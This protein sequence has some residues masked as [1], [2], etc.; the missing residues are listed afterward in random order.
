MTSSSLSAK[1]VTLLLGF[2]RHPVIAAETI[3][4][5]PAARQPTQ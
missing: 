1:S 5:D 2:A 4:I 3:H